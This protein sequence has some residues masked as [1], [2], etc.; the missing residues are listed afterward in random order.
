M[1]DFQIDLRILI[2]FL[3]IVILASV[4]RQNEGFADKDIPC[5]SIK[6]EVSNIDGVITTLEQNLNNFTTQATSASTGAPLT[7]TLMH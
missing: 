3:I 7:L 1:G 4:L 6:E 2:V 5:D